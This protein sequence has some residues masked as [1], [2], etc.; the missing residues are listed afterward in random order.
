LLHHVDIAA[1]AP[2]LGRLA[3]AD[4]KIAFLETMATNPFLR[5]ARTHL[6]GRFHIPKIG[7]EDEHPLDRDDMA[8]LSR[9]LGPLRVEVREM[10][11]FRMVDRQMLGGR[12]PRVSHVLRTVDDVLGKRP[13]L[14][15]LSYDQVLVFD[16]AN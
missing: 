10:H 6:A 15:Y 9:S 8:T 3:T 2:V 13:S 1:A 11:F 16:R 4:A 12:Y 14:S 5:V 7:T